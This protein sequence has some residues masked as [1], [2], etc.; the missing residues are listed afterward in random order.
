MGSPVLFVQK[1]IGLNCTVFKMYKFRTM[2]NS[3]SMALDPEQDLLRITKLGKFL[4][5]SSLDELPELFN[6]LKGD[7]SL[8]G[9]RP[10]LPEYL[11]YYDKNQIR[12]HLVRPGITGYAQVSGRNLLSWNEKF[13]MDVWYVEN[14][15]FWL[16]IEIL[17]KTIKVIL[18]REG[19]TNRSGKIMTR[20]D[21]EGVCDE[22]D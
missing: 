16:Y 21:Q 22:K 14:L 4:R 17:L 19:V 5:D 1:R 7:M 20:F 8:V 3:N 2:K 13:K 6:V 9:P 10:L 12:R 11:P 15:S 18:T